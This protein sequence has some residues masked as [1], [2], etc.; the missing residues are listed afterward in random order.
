MPVPLR[1]ATRTLLE[2]PSRSWLLL[3]AVALSAALIACV[4]AALTS[5]NRAVDVRL[6]EMIGRADVLI[7]PAS[8]RSLEET[9]LRT[10]RAW[11]E[12]QVATGRLLEG[13]GFRATINAYLPDENPLATHP[14]RRVRIPVSFSARAVGFEPMVEDRFRPLRLVAG[15]LPQKPGE[16]AIDVAAVESLARQARRKPTGAAPSPEPGPLVAITSEAAAERA[17]QQGTL[18]LGSTLDAVRLFRTPTPLT[19]VG[20]VASPPLGGRWQV[21]MTREQLGAITDNTGRLSQIDILLKP[22]ADPE[23]LVQA[24]RSEMG[25]RVL[26]QTTAKVTGGVT[27]NMRANQLGFYLATTMAFLAAAFIITTGLS[28]G[29]IERQRQLAILRCIGSS[30]ATLAWAQVL[31]GG[32]LGAAGAV[33]GVPLGLGVCAIILYA[34]RDVIPTGL[35]LSGTPF[36]LPSAGAVACG[37]LG[38]VYPAWAASRVSPLQ[39]LSVRARPVQPR[40]MIWLSLAGIGAILFNIVV[41]TTIRDAQLLFWIYATTGLPLL[42][43]GYFLLG[44]A[45]MRGAV[46]AL[47]GV[48]TRG[49]AL[50]PRLLGRTAQATPYRLGFTA[51]AMMSGLAIMVAIWTQG[52]A[53]RDD[54]L[55]RMRFPDAFAAGLHVSPDAIERIGAIPFVTDLCP[56][57]I[58]PVESQTFGV[59]ALQRYKSSFIAFEPEPFFRMTHLTWLQPADEAGQQAARERL[60]RGGAVIVAREF[61]AASGI[62]VGGRIRLSHADREHEFEIVGVVTSPGLEVVGSF[63]ETADQFADQAIH[64]VFGTRADLRDRFGS[65]AVNMIQ[66]D[67]ADTVSD[68]EAIATLRGVLLETGVL[69]VGSGRSVK[70]DLHTIVRGS[71]LVMTSIA[72]FALVKASLGVANIIIAGVHTRRFEF[73]VLRAVGASRGMLVRLIL[74]EGVLVGVV[75]IVL[76]TI[77]GLQGVAQGQVLDRMLLGLEL[78]L[79]PPLVPIL[80]G[81]AAVLGACL[82]AALPPALG[83]ARQGP[84]ELL[85]TPRG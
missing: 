60:G 55:E 74:A 85:A 38:G 32:L 81:W 25:D 21:Y 43:I 68:D 16:I 48:L 34:A 62:G 15:R 57:T 9:L 82:L 70:R 84:R 50:P 36:L 42:F 53:V 69:E 77:L 67:L 33:I 29:V 59:R 26:L 3:G 78:T 39:G 2:R 79:R 52:R 14:Y 27:A 63:F 31:S 17:T 83:I 58:L 22:G 49:L 13:L 18:A 19:I 8:G 40:L 72:L 35:A 51:S 75:A 24:R 23:A 41:F 28:T 46:A 73:G 11:P 47:S 37:V 76:G 45:V 12:T 1:L 20:H 7:K 4:A 61:F 5:V 66:M 71:L 44:P 54:W 56:I 10:V 80:I 6:Q 30:R 65:D 64:A